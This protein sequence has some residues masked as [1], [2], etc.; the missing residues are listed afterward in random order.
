VSTTS[1]VARGA[2]AAALSVLLL[3]AGAPGF[4]QPAR[5]Y[6][7]VQEK[8]A[9]G[10]RVVGGTVISS[11][12]EIYCAMAN[13]GF[14]FLWIEMQHSPLTFQE[15]ARMIWACRGAPAIPFIRVPDATAGD[16]Q[17]ATDIG[18]LGIIVPLV[19]SVEKIRAAV[20]YTMYPPAGVRSLGNGQ[21][22]ALWGN[23]YRATANDN[24]M[25]VAMIE[26]PAGAAIADEIAA[27]PGV[28][29]VFAASTDLGSFSGLRQGEA[30]YEAMVTAIHDATLGAGRK[31]GGPLAWGNRDGFTF[32]QAPTEA[33]FIRMGVERALAEAPSGTAPIEGAER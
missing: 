31:L 26:S 13:S 28:D 12:P 27:V 17:K 11:D 10:E 32:F 4:S 29:V 18:A 21:Y 7:T 1:A 8:L 33:T 5:S 14:D 3:T 20:E 23:D 9:R 22:G 24:I 16:I 2:A 15:V 30:D 19:D 6:N 25:V